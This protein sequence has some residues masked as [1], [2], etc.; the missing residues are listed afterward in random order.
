MLSPEYLQDVTKELEDYFYDLET[1]IL[2]DIAERIRLNDKAMTSTASYQL[3]QLKALGVSNERINEYMS[4]ALK[5]S[6]KQ[7][8]QLISNSVYKSIKNDNVIFKEAFEKGLIASFSYDETKFKDLIVEG[9][10]ATRNDL[11][12]ICNTTA[13]T[14]QAK[15]IEAM[16]SVYLQVSSGAFS[17]DQ[18]VNN[19]VT[20]LASD[21]L[22][23]IEYKSGAR[24]HIDTAVRTCLR[25]SINKTACKAQEQNLD[26]FGCNLVEVTSHL[27]A[28]PEHQEWQGKIYWRL[29]KYKNYKNFEE[30]TRYGKGD[31]LG[32]WNCRHSFYPFFEGISEKTFEHYKAKE[33]NELYEKQQE[34]RYN[35]RKIR[36]WKR[37]RDVKK[38][39]GLD[40]TK[41]SEKVRYW[42]KRNDALIKS[43]D[44]LK[45]NYGREKVYLSRKNGIIDTSDIKITG[46][47]DPASKKASK[48]AERYYESVRKMKT[49]YKKIA[50]NTGYSEKLIKRIKQYSF[51]DEHELLNGKE[52]FYPDYHIAESWQRLIEGKNI[53]PH[54]LLLLE[55][56][57]YELI[58]V[59][60][61]FSQIDA[62]NLTNQIYNYKKGC[63]EYD[64]IFK[65]FYKK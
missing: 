13:K 15:F 6:K 41:E 55:H 26:D 54:D 1:E 29:H 51:I 3:E 36:E 53:Q 34:Q 61:G 23:V 38:A 49:D 24:R 52:R 37:R 44:R 57:M 9:V 39:A 10:I 5:I 58:L 56:E 33:N 11:T 12:N 30:S 40:V 43:D 17:M 63:D 20:K 31:G 42:N 46:A 60:D 48:H 45:H 25:S 35:E 18:A 21:G 19:V 7:A 8:E 64:G 65:K 50:I 4:K 22:G 28:R 62:H 27:G 2:K 16:N 14:A 47:L 59:E 32:G